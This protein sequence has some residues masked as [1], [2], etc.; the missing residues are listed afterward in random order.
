MSMD[1]ELGQN[2]RA[3]LASWAACD[4]P[5][6][7]AER[8]MRRALEQPVVEAQRGRRRELAVWRFGVVAAA[9][10]IVLGLVFIA[11]GGSAAGHDADPN[12]ARTFAQQ[13]LLRHCTP[14]H[15]SLHEGADPEAV[16]VF[17]VDRDDWDATISSQALEIS[18]VK[19]A[20]R[21]TSGELAGFRS[22]VDGELAR[23]RGLR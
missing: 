1:S 9:A 3:Q 22:Y 20:S 5:S 15:G 8:V 18:T 2:E 11:P 23:R 16:S 13:T 17:D 21:T 7:F 10:A 19:L 14:C 12:A 4:V 6:D